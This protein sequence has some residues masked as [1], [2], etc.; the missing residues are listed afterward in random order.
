[1]KYAFLKSKTGKYK[2]EF[3]KRFAPKAQNQAVINGLVNGKK[4]LKLLCSTDVLSEGQNLQDCGVII[5]YDLHW[6]PVKM[7]Q[8]NGRINRL[9]SVF[10]IVNVYN[11]R[12][13]DQLDKFLKLMLKLQEKIQVIGASVGLDSSVLGEDITPKQFGLIENIYSD[14]KTKQTEAV[15]EL[16]RENDLAFDEVF[17]NDL[18]EFM[19]KA[20]DEEKERIR[21]L[22]LDKWCKINS[23][24]K[25]QRLLIYNIAKGEFRFHKK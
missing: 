23:L 11:F 20:S 7:V 1:M 19:R 17:E 21:T 12:P 2:S 8:R 18:R 5:N 25:E 13:E 16:E 14:D 22:N 9:G 15:R 3:V 24:T 10:E 6:N 4:E